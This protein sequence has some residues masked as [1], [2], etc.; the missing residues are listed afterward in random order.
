MSSRLA[1]QWVGAVMVLSLMWGCATHTPPYAW[2]PEAPEAATPEEFRAGGQPSLKELFGGGHKLDMGWTFRVITQEELNRLGNK[3]PELSP[4]FSRA[5]LARL[6]ARAR[7]YIAEDI[8]KGRPLKVPNDFKAFKHWTPMPKYI[9]EVVTIPK[10]IVVVKDIPFLGWYENGKLMTDTEIC[11]GKNEEWTSAGIYRV[12]NKDANHISRSYTNAYGQPAPMPW[13]L[14]IYGHVW[15]HA[16]DIATGYCSHG[17][18][19][20]P[21]MPATRLFDWADPGTPVLVLESLEDLKTI[22]VRNQSNCKLY[23]SACERK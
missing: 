13:A 9:P 21:M 22:L 10:F 7:Y 16:G 5:I 8:E 23:T 18:I 12:E 4:S 20:L 6:N 19:N 3:D 2:I 15:I 17:C 1:W 14:R 11:I